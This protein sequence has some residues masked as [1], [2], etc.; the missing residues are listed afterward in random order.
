MSVTTDDLRRFDELHVEYRERIDQSIEETLQT[1]TEDDHLREVVARGVDGGKRIRPTFTLVVAEL[2]GLPRSV[3]VDRGTIVELIHSATLVADD[4]ADDDAVRRGSPALWR[5]VMRLPF[6]GPDRLNPRTVT[7][8]AENGILALA[9]RLA[10]EPDVVQAMGA[11][12]Q[13]VFRGFYEEEVTTVDGFFGGGYDA[14]IDINELKTGGM[15]A[16]G[17]HLAALTTDHDEE[18]IQ[19]ARD[20]GRA[21]GI[22]YQIADDACDDDLPDCVD[23]PASQLQHWYDETLGHLDRI[24]TT[25]DRDR[26]LL[27]TVPAWSVQK[28]FDREGNASVEIPFVEEPSERDRQRWTRPSPLRETGSSPE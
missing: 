9:L 26:W 17:C 18:A 11:T 25:S 8:L 2:Y 13:D 15:F 28:M 14:Y 12:V 27:S 10:D 6:V 21:A 16:L 23:D 5:V 7:V 4:Y 3:A 20:Y 24:P 1:Y 19:A 22:L